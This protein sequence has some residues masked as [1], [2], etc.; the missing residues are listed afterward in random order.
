MTVFVAFTNPLFQPAMR[1]ILAITQAQYAEVTTAQPHLYI[2]GT[3]VR[4]YIPDNYRGKSYGMPE[5]NHQFAE[6]TV[7]G[8]ST[9]TV[10]INSITYQ[11]FII[12]A[13][14]VQYAMCVPIGE[15]NDTLRAAEL[16]KFDK[17]IYGL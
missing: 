3:I 8:A 2:S 15:N 12:P 11:P 5:I 17:Y 6:I 1:Q 9:F 4:F 10:P 13:N 7:T 16:N 14:P